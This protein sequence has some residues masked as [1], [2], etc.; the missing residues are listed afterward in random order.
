M[1]PAGSGRS[2]PHDRGHLPLFIFPQRSLQHGASPRSHL[3]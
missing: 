2:G 1:N 3:S